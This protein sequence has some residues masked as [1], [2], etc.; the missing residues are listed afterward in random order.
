LYNSLHKGISL[1]MSESLVGLKGIQSIELGCR[2]LAA[3]ADS[4]RPLSL[5]E[6]ARAAGMPPSN[7]RRYL[8]SFVRTGLAEQDRATSL[9]DLSWFSL[10]LGLAALERRDVLRMGRP[11]LRR[12]CDS[13]DQTVA[14]VAWTQAGPIVV[15]FEE[16][17][18][19]VLRL[20]AP[21]GAT[22]PLTSTAAGRVFAAWMAPEKT[23]SI[24]MK[25][26]RGEGRSTYASRNRHQVD[27]DNVI[28]EVKSRGLARMAGSPAEGVS[29]MA[30]PV[31]GYGGALAAAL[32]ALGYRGSFDLSWTG[33]IATGL[34]QAAAELSRS[35]GF[36]QIQT[37]ST[38]NGTDRRAAR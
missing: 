19:G 31:F 22:L 9:Y 2:L 37:G 7:A 11:I 32:V 30:V 35:L 1:T 25:E 27:L 18:R 4:G 14:L 8:I 28:A 21:L 12:L 36:M 6:I 17:D 20:V 5:G 15:H 33:S 16:S 3:L 24:I 13:L 10:H 38:Q 23:Q 26:V 29:T 34:K